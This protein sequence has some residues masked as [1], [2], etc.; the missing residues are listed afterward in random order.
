LK[1]LKCLNI[2][3]KLSKQSLVY[4]D[5]DSRRSIDNAIFYYEFSS[6]GSYIFDKSLLTISIDYSDKITLLNTD[7]N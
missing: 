5:M 3:D 4:K 2:F 7:H 1:T 6:C